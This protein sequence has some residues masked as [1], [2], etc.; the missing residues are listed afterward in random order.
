MGDMKIGEGK[1]YDAT[2]VSAE[3]LTQEEIAELTKKNKRLIKIFQAYDTDGKAGLSSTE[4][5]AAMDDFIKAA[6]ED[7]KI[8]KKEFEKM[9]DTFNHWNELSGGREVSGEDLKNFMKAIRKGTK[10]DEKVS[11][12]QLLEERQKKAD[13]QLR[14]LQ[15]AREQE[16]MQQRAREFAENRSQEILQEYEAE[17]QAK[18]KQE[19][20]AARIRDLQTPKTYTVQENE[21]FKDLIKRSLAAQGIENPTDEQMKEAIAKFKQD[22]PGAVHTTKKGVEYL[23]AGAE[24]KIAGNLEDKG[25]SDEIE[26]ALL[27]RKAAAEEA[28][29]AAEEKEKQEKGL[30]P[31]APKEQEFEMPDFN[32]GFMPL[33]GEFDPLNPPFLQAPDGTK[34]SDAPNNGQDGQSVKP[35]ENEQPPVQPASSGVIK[36]NG[37]DPK[38]GKWNNK[39][40]ANVQDRGLCKYNESLKGYELYNGTYGGKYYEN[41][42]VKNLATK[43]LVDYDRE[44]TIRRL[45]VE[46]ADK[47]PSQDYRKYNT[48]QYANG[49]LTPLYRDPTYDSNVQI[50]IGDTTYELAQGRSAGPFGEDG[51]AH[52]DFKDFLEDF[53]DQ[54]TGAIRANRYVAN[55]YYL[56]A[57]GNEGWLPVTIDRQTKALM[58][59]I[60]GKK[61]DMNDLMTG[62]V[63]I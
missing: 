12:Q 32:V 1:K 21:S 14:Q 56:R 24:V 48:Y 28:R 26:A 20:E 33:D 53:V 49:S 44:D 36:L 30:P 37:A 5:A 23:Y 51:Y 35:P 29:I 7:N 19:A 41:G 25:N 31:Y 18:A 54:D 43:T 3:G 16:E 42:Q 47:H 39:D 27:K 4:L 40:F 8:S 52:W 10:K 17:Q 15:E 60:N 59:E 38:T 2:Q 55:K 57:N 61:Y 46:F 9:A 50:K 11:T 62:K 63:K 45:G 13:A 58:V 34:K 22:N 6:G